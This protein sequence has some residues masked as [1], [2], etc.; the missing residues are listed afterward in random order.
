M[1][2]YEVDVP[3]LTDFI[4]YTFGPTNGTRR[5]DKSQNVTWCATKYDSTTESVQQWAFCFKV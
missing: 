3:K 1:K 4:G 5:S 2:L